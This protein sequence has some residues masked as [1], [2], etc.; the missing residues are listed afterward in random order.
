MASDSPDYPPPRR[1]QRP[2][3]NARAKRP[4]NSARAKRFNRRPLPADDAPAGDASDATM[5]PQDW[6]KA[7]VRLRHYALYYLGRFDSTSGKLSEIL[8]RYLNRHGLNQLRP[9][10]AELVA[11]M[12]QAGYINDQRFALRAAER[13]LNAGK[14]RQ[15]ANAWLLQRQLSAP[16]VQ[17]ALAQ[18]YDTPQRVVGDDSDAD[19]GAAWVEPELLAARRFAAKRRLGNY[20]DAQDRAQRFAKDLAKMARAG[21]GYDLCRQV[22]G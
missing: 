2:D 8:L 22:L 7:A 20:G 17:E 10:V 1:V 6:E 15:Q 9:K 3:N 21:F 14:S 18:L 12:V 11:E 16:Q 4:D 13:A 5:T 19:D